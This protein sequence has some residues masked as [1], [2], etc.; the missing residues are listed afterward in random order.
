MKNFKATVK[1]HKFITAASVA[2]LLLVIAFLAWPRSSI[3]LADID[4][5]DI[6]KN[7]NGQWELHAD[8]DLLVW[9]DLPSNIN[10]LDAHIES[11][12]P[13]EVKS[14]ETGTISFKVSCENKITYASQLNFIAAD[15]LTLGAVCNGLNLRNQTIGI[16]N[17]T[18]RMFQWMEPGKHAYVHY[19]LYT[20]CADK[21]D[22]YTIRGGQSSTGY[23]VSFNI[24]ADGAPLQNHTDSYPG[25]SAW[26][27]K[28]EQYDKAL[29]ESTWWKGY[30]EQLEE[31]EMTPSNEGMIPEID[32]LLELLEMCN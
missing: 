14:G 4:G 21:Y 6:P 32:D 27:E 19:P 18:C 10:E 20:S 24:T 1:N 26:R 13:Y 7:A 25:E 9:L 16:N 2:A 30:R 23:N 28:Y 17:D 29:E 22:V 12:Y 31:L 8:Q 11:S 3:R 5:Y 15:D